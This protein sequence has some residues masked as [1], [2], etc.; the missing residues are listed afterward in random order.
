MIV[1]NDSSIEALDGVALRGLISGVARGRAYHWYGAVFG[2]RKTREMIHG[3]LQDATLDGMVQFS[4][5][6]RRQT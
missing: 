6:E 5:P 2:T 1:S 4:G 3:R